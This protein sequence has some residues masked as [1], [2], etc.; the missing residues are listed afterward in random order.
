MGLFAYLLNCLFNCLLGCLFV[1]CLFVYVLYGS[2]KFYF[3]RMTDHCTLH[4]ESYFAKDIDIVN[5]N[6]L[7]SIE[8]PE[9]SSDLLQIILS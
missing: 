2:L 6:S 4:K 3:D 9:R 7:Y 1:P 5:W 8:I